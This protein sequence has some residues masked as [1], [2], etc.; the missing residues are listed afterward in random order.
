MMRRAARHRPGTDPTRG[1]LGCGGGR[2][3]GRLPPLQGLI[4]WNTPA[5][6][7]RGTPL[8][9][10]DSATSDAIP[11]APP[12]ELHPPPVS[13]ASY[14]S[15]KPKHRVALALAAVAVLLA[16][17]LV[18]RGRE[19]ACADPAACGFA[20]PKTD[21]RRGATP[22]GRAF[23][24]LPA[25][26][27]RVTRPLLESRAIAG[28]PEAA[29][30][31]GE[32]FGRCRE[33]ES[34]ADSTFATLLAGLVGMF[35][36]G[37]RMGDERISG[38]EA[39]GLLSDAKADMDALCNGTQGMKASMALADAHRWNHHAATLA[40]TGAMAAYADHAFSEFATV[41][42]LMDH[43]A[44][45]ARRRETARTMIDRALRAGEPEALKA[46]ALAHGKDGW[47]RRDP[48][49]ALAYWNAYRHTPSGQALSSTH[50]SLWERQLRSRVDP[51]GEARARE[52]ARGLLARHFQETGK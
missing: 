2:T 51:T 49:L 14:R 17:V 27:F 37:L 5:R 26:D 40:H 30:R 38:I 18:V 22:A 42:D 3:G 8:Y 16:G 20:V 31:L 44:E 9:L 7:T 25:G 33:Y 10:P 11:A 29:F 23:G 43:T 46:L 41:A 36:G 13:T 15:M 48:V 32:V 4:D 6:H 12:A 34:L 52:L 35:D 39:I 19:P 21:A 28:D 47:M 1:R 50:A 24:P 45:V